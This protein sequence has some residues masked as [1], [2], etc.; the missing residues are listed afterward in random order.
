M[1]FMSISE[2]S[3]TVF[4]SVTLCIMHSI[5]LMFVKFS[6]EKSVKNQFYSFYSMVVK[7]MAN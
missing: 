5:K 1:Y 4:A 3:E 6:I 7:T 2:I